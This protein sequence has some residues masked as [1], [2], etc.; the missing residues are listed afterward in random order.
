MG[1]GYQVETVAGVERPFGEIGPG[2]ATYSGSATGWILDLPVL[3]RGSLVQLTAPFGGDGDLYSGVYS[4][5]LSPSGALSTLSNGSVDI[6]A[7]AV[8]ATAYR[9]VAWFNYYS[10]EGTSAANSNFA[11][12]VAGLARPTP[13]NNIPTSGQRSYTSLLIGVMAGN[14]ADLVAA[15]G[16]LKVDF[17]A[18]R[19]SG[20]LDVGLS[21]FMG[22]S[23]PSQ[24]YRLIGTNFDPA[25]GRFTVT[26]SGPD[27]QLGTY[28]AQLAG[29]NGSEIL[30][31]TKFDYREPARAKL[32]KAQAVLI[33]R[34]A[35]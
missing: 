9:D 35:T 26:F 24:R 32:V 34:V 10:F 11:S 12:G 18:G 7:P 33:G 6:F 4:A 19:L 1:G 22:C 17:A 16:G 23:Y 13:T 3:G 14:F 20:D 8:A 21:C 25:T 30:L 5:G 2:T 15:E 29:P 28:S 31:S 27:G